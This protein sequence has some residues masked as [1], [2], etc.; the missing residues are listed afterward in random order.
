MLQIE[1]I[2]TGIGMSEETRARLF[3]PF[4]QADASTTRR[5]GGTGLGLTISRRLAELLGGDISVRSEVGKGSTFTLRVP[6]GP[7]DGVRLIDAPNECECATASEKADTAPARATLPAGCR[8][9]LA[10]DGPD[11]QRLIAFL[12]RKAGAEVALAENGQ[13]AAQIALAAQEEARPFDAVLM[14]MQ[15]PVMDGYDATRKLRNAGYAFPIIALTAHA[16]EGDRQKC[17]DAGCDDYAAK[18]IDRNTLLATVARHVEAHRRLEPSPDSAP[19][20]A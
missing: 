7:L 17:L 14:D 6:T 10:E 4:S 12:L 16:M 5:F 20:V 1:V 2:D 13:Q 8:L 9:L 15:M 18:P 19:A 11:N 3:Q